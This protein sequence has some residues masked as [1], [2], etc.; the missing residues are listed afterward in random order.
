MKDYSILEKWIDDYNGAAI[1]SLVDDK[2]KRYIGQAIRLQQRLETHRQVLTRAFKH[3]DV[4]VVENENLVNAVRNGIKFKVEILYKIPRCKATVNMLRYY[5]NY[6]FQKY[7]GYKNTYNIAPIS[8][9]VWSCDHF[10]IIK[11]KSP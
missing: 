3:K 2:G 10:N 6:Y 11:T 9:P 5:E 8:A 7:G 4:Y 1:Y